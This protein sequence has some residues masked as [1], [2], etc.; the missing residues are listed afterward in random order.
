M[1]HWEMVWWDIWS[2]LRWVVPPLLFFLSGVLA[3]DQ[4]TPEPFVFVGGAGYFL[5]YAAMKGWW[6]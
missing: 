2:A 5:Y 3:R 6:T 4:D 1:N